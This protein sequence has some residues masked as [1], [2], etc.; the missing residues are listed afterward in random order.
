MDATVVM[1]VCRGSQEYKGKSSK[2]REDTK[3]YACNQGLALYLSQDRRES[4]IHDSITKRYSLNSPE[5][6]AFIARD[7]GSV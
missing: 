3:K 2:Q 5:R 7:M 4:Y 6:K 1:S